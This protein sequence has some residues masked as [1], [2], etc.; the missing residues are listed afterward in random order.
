MCSSG[1]V[2]LGVSRGRVVIGNGRWIG[3]R[4]FG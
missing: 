4:T 2:G 1:K 3:L